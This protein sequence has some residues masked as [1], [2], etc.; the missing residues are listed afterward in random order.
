MTLGDAMR[1]KKR[2]QYIVATAIL[3]A[4]IFVATAIVL[5]GTPFFAQLLIILSA[6]MV[7]S[8]IVTPLVLSPDR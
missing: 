4:V 3:W 2:A 6:G 1:E 8:V 5:R 7:W